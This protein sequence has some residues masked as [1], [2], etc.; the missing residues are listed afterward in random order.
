M[1]V[2]ASASNFLLLL[3]PWM[4]NVELAVLMLLVRNSLSQLDVPTRS[5]TD[6][7][8]RCRRTRGFGWNS[9]S[10][11]PTRALPSR[12]CLL[13]QYWQFDTGIAVLVGGG[14]KIIYDLWVFAVFRNVKPP[15]EKRK[16]VA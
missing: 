6:G 9:L 4:P 16:Q 7:C 5:P 14:L 15:E 10:R 8:R 2:Y 3:V 12:R 1:V 13:A 11:P